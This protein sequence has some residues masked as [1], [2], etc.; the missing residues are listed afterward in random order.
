MTTVL[1]AAKPGQEDFRQEPDRA[2]GNGG[3]VDFVTD[4]LVD[5]LRTVNDRIG[6]AP[7]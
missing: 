6:S 4:D 1:V 7:A 5:F 2:L 3:E